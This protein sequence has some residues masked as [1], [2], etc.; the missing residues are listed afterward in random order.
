MKRLTLSILTALTLILTA[1]SCSKK[2][3]H[4]N[5][6]KMAEMIESDKEL[7][8]KDYSDILDQTEN[9]YEHLRKAFDQA[10]TADENDDKDFDHSEWKKSNHLPESG[11]YFRTMVVALSDGYNNGKMPEKLHDRYNDLGKRIT[12]WV[13]DFPEMRNYLL[14]GSRF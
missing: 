10:K 6:R 12:E 14:Y 1:S 7:T 8:E 4:E 5:A 11:E 13:E 3:D 2:Y 9:S